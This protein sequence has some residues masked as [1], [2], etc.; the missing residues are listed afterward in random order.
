M[1]IEIGEWHIY[2]QE[3]DNKPY[4]CQIAYIP[5]DSHND[6]KGWGEDGTVY[7]IRVRAPSIETALAQAMRIVNVE[8][9]IDMCSIPDEH[10]NFMGKESLTYDEIQKIVDDTREKGWRSSFWMLIEPINTII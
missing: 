9:A 5:Q 6:K 2:S 10:P 8:R 1:K 7:K 3:P 4:I